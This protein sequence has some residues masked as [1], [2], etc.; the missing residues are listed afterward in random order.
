M[1]IIEKEFNLKD[2][3]IYQERNLNQNILSTRLITLGKYLK[4]SLHNR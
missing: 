3:N 2:Y 4:Q 1:N